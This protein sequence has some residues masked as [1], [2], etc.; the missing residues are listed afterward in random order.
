MGRFI[1]P[2]R[3]AFKH[4]IKIFAWSSSEPLQ[5]DKPPLAVHPVATIP[6]KTAQAAV[7]SPTYCQCACH[8]HYGTHRNQA[9]LTGF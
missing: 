1:Q 6:S 4:K 5:R 7:K 2:P 3:Q 8:I 9:S